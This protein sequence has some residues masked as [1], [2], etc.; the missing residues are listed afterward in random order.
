MTTDLGQWPRRVIFKNNPLKVVV[1]QVRFS[2][3]LVLAQPAGVAQFQEAIRDAYPRAE[4]PAQQVT[5]AVGP[6]GFMP[7]IGQPGPW[8]FL[9]ESGWV[10]GLATDYVSLEATKYEC[11]EQFEPRA[12]MVLK[13]AQDT[14][15]LR[16]RGRLGLRYVNEINHPD[17]FT[18]ADW[19]TLLDP[20]LLGVCGGELFGDRVIQ[21]LQQIDLRLDEGVLTVRHG[22][23]TSRE[24]P[25]P[26]VIDLDAHDDQT[27]PFDVDEILERVGFF[28][29]FIGGFFRHSLAKPLYDFLGPQEPG[30]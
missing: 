6:T 10:V 11:F 25:H 14:L 22:C 8:R 17:A 28:R 1:L 19:R 23:N 15:A 30:D 13:A 26:Y 16:E 21:T 18:V 24:G 27:R 5:L 12:A 7:P 20:E 2:P 3:I 9:D 29:T 4:A